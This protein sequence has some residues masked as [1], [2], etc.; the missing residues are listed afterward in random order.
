MVY[1]SKVECNI[2]AAESTIILE[3]DLSTE[4]DRLE[5]A[6][7]SQWIILGDS[8]YLYIMD[9][10]ENYHIPLKMGMD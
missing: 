9:P 5:R 3:W 7:L 10:T 2:L 8:D 1:Y 6:I 4:F